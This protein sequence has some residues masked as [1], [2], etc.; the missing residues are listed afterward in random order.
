[1]SQEIAMGKGPLP[2]ETIIKKTFKA[3]NKAQ[4]DYEKWTGGFW[5]WE[6]PE[7]MLT[8]Y[9]AR[10]IS[11]IR[12][13]TYYLTLEN[14]VREALGDAGGLNRGR[15]LNA[16]RLNG[17]MDILLWRAN[18]TPRVA[19]EVKNQVSSFLQIK[20]DVDRICSLLKK[21]NNTFQC[22]L[23]TFYTSCRDRGNVCS[24]DRILQ[25]LKEMESDGRE[26]IQKERMNLSIQKNKCTIDGDSAWLAVVWEIRRK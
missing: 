17:R 20:D 15:P 4:S 22:G 25:R 11:T 10:E 14:S 3:I 8:T 12:N 1:M 18:D 16:L 6:A 19:I 21:R 24:Q 9:I 7:Y 2:I 26:F 13:H 23:M 5:L